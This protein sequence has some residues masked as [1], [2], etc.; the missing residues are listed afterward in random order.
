MRPISS[1]LFGGYGGRRRLEVFGEMRQRAHDRIGGEASQRAKRPE[2]H[3]IA[4]IGYQID[5][6]LRRDAGS[7]SVQHF[8]APLRADT[9]GRALAAALDGAEFHGEARLPEHVSAVVEDDD[10]RMTDQP[11]LCREGPVVEGRIEQRPREV[12]AKRAADLHGL[13]WS[14]G[15]RSSADLVD[16]LAQR[17]PEARLEQ[18]AMADIPGDL[19]RNGA[20]RT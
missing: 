20:A 16:D 13:D 9:A 1:L 6:L 2:L 11:I 3:R 7:Q 18:P 15:S 14:A 10:A 5:L 12:G 19:D 8:H 4:E 17:Q